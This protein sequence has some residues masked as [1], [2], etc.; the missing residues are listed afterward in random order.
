MATVMGD[1]KKGE[2]DGGKIARRPRLLQVRD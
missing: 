2:A 1:F